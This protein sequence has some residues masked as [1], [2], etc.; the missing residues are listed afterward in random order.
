MANILGQLSDIYMTRRAQA[1]EK[2][3]LN[4]KVTLKDLKQMDLDG[5]GKV[6]YDEFLVFMLVA[7][8]KVETRDIHQIETLYHKLDKDK[9][10]SVRDLFEKAYVAET[11]PESKPKLE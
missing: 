5:D 3:F 11:I 10:L 9:C 6:T 2:E 4:R 8:G 1:N 7:M